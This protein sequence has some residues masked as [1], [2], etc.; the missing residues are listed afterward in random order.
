M[1]WNNL[2]LMKKAKLNPPQQ[3]IQFYISTYKLNTHTT[4]SA[5]RHFRILQ[6]NRTTC[7]VRLPVHKR[8]NPQNKRNGATINEQTSHFHGL[9]MNLVRSTTNVPF[10][11]NKRWKLKSDDDDDDYDIIQN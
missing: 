4:I 5:I 7:D 11:T 6:A 1:Y 8:S 9:K 3:S 2:V 10:I